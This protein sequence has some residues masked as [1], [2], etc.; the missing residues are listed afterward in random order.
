MPAEITQA[1]F[2]LVYCTCE[3]DGVNS[4]DFLRR[5]RGSLI[6]N[7]RYTN[8]LVV[9]SA[10]IAGKIAENILSCLRTR[11]SISIVE[12]TDESKLMTPQL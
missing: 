7:S 4:V 11:T 10:L 2:V 6:V 1:E 5:N 8:T 9:R 12:A 3:M